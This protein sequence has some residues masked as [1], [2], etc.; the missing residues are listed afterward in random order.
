MMNGPV[1]WSSRKQKSVALST[2]EAEYMALADAIKEIMW[3][4]GLL[5]SMGYTMD[6]PTIIYEDNNACIELARD[7][8]HRERAKHIDVRYHF[9]R[10]LISKKVVRIERC[11]SEM[12]LADGLTKA[13][14]I[15]RFKK[16]NELIGVINAP[17]DRGVLRMTSG[18]LGGAE[19]VSELMEMRR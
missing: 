10:D 2:M 5:K 14:P 12:Q 16:L 7:P 1:I 9:I 17:K 4:R 8:K 13:L 11:N 15:E 3:V 18:A 19:S 6:E